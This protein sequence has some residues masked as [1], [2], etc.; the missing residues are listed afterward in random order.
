MVNPDHSPP[1]HR[2]SEPASRSDR[3]A[4]RPPR[5]RR[6]P[7]LGQ[8]FQRSPEAGEA[9]VAAQDLHGLEQRWRDG[10]PGNGHAEK[11]EERARL[12]A[13]LF[14]HGAQA[15]FKLLMPPFLLVIEPIKGS[16]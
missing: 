9:A 3:P 13:Q 15:G 10:A 14:R 2:P 4:A 11:P 12:Q 1:T 5:P 16:L 6:R 8:S 7:G